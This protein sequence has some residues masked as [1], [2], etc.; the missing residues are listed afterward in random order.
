MEGSGDPKPGG[1]T[2]Q[3]DAVVDDMEELAPPALSHAE[4]A[5]P[6]LPP[7][8]VSTG[9]W[10]AGGAVVLVA[11]GLAL[12][13]GFMLFGGETPPAAASSEEVVEPPPAPA[14]AV[15]PPTEEPA[16]EAEPASIQMDDIVF[17]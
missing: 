10:V 13:V 16:V 9:M 12:G 14:E 17:E 8:K 15:A 2:M 6:P 4:G 11:A 7:K 5:P 3:L 1:A